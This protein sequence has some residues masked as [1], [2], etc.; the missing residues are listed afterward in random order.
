MGATFLGHT[1]SIVRATDEDG[2]PR[3]V[4]GGC[5]CADTSRVAGNCHAAAKAA[6]TT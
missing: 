1:F 3:G 5:G 6:E 4:V 2:P